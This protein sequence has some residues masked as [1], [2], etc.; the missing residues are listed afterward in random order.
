MK[1]KLAQVGLIVVILVALGLVAKS[2]KPK[3]Y[4]YEKLLVDVQANKVFLQ[5]VVVGQNLEIPT[6][7]PFSEGKNAYPVYKC[8]K[9]NTIFA[10]EEPA[11]S[12]DA[13]SA[14]SAVMIPKCPVCGSM[15]IDIPDLPAG[16]QS[17]DVPGPVQI[18]KPSS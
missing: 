15:E 2:V 14:D 9:D 1:Q 8:M 4:T 10:F 5:K 11:F 17:I 6:S 18:V 16:Q 12:P 13:Q 3:P 7:S